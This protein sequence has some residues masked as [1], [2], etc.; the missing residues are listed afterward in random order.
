MTT[1]HSSEDCPRRRSKK[2]VSRG[3][4]RASRMCGNEKRR[5]LPL[6]GEVRCDSTDVAKLHTSRMNARGLG[7]G[8]P[9]SLVSA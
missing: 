3:L 1:S 8:W 2:T 7:H 6:M 4:K 5:R 9:Q